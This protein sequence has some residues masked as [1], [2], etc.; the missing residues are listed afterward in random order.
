M[1]DH[2]GFAVSDLKKSKYFYVA[3]LRILGRQQ[4]RSG[5]P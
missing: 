5:M 1:I 4:Y 3:A 2:I